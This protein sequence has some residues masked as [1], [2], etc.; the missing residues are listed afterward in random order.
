M[1]WIPIAFLVFLF[2]MAASITSDAINANNRRKEEAYEKE[3]DRFINAVTD[4]RLEEE[5]RHLAVSLTKEERT[6]FIAEF[7]G[8]P[9]LHWEYLT[10]PCI[11]GASSNEYTDMWGTYV[12]AYMASKGKLPDLGTYSICYRSRSYTIDGRR[13]TDQMAFMF[14]DKVQ[15]ILRSRYPELGIELL[16]QPAG[17]GCLVY[18]RFNEYASKYGIDGLKSDVARTS[19]GWNK[20]TKESSI[21]AIR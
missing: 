10:F 16:I 13:E 7:V 5:A 18:Y 3:R 8:A 11:Y 17:S 14:M 1:F 12:L 6:K 2:H 20:S 4:K 21:T 15:K 9:D 19:F